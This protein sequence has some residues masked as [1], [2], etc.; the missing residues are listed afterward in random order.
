MP[1]HQ[2]TLTAEIARDA[3]SLRLDFP[4]AGTTNAAGDASPAARQDAPIAALRDAL[5]EK[6][7]A[8]PPGTSVPSLFSSLGRYWLAFQDSRRRRRLRVSLCDLSEAQLMDI[9]LAQNDIDHIAA[10]RALERLKDNT[11][12]LLTSRGVM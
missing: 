11:A 2:T 3:A 6:D 8:A 10:H 7:A 12:H 4:I 5:S 1:P 9:G